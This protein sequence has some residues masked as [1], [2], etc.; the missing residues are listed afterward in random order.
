MSSPDSEQRRDQLLLSARYRVGETFLHVPVGKAQK[1]LAADREAILK[2][3]DDLQTR[4]GE[5]AE[6][7]KDLKVVLYAKFGKAINLD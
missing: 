5:C 7:M 4:L 6:E 3:I 1:M 2:E